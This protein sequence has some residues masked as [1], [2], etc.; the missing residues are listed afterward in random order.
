MRK[1]RNSVFAIALSWT[2]WREALPTILEFVSQG[3][4]NIRNLNIYT[5]IKRN[6]K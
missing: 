3:F 2:Y 6:K 1:K 5:N 4:L